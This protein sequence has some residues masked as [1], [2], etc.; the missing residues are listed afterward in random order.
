MV[1]DIG[2]KTEKVAR[3]IPNLTR[4][5]MRRNMFPKGKD[6][7]THNGRFHIV[8][9]SVASIAR[10]CWGGDSSKKKYPRYYANQALRRKIKKFHP[11]EMIKIKD[12]KVL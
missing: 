2:R 1:F 5:M 3:S 8:V 11:H 4:R 6:G 9:S 10:K 7:K 12:G